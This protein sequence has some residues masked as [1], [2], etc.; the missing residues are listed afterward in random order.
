MPEMFQY[1]DLQF[2]K[3]EAPA[4]MEGSAGGEAWGL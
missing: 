3:V 4:L 1:K 2:Q